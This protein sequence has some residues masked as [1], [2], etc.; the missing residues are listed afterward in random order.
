MQYCIGTKLVMAREMTLGAYNTYRGWALPEDEDGTTLGY[1]VEYT[2]G[3]KANHKDHVGYISWSPATVFEPANT[4]FN[5]LAGAPPYVIRMCAEFAELSKKVGMLGKVLHQEN[6]DKFHVAD[7]I[8]MDQQ[9]H[10][11][12]NYLRILRT[13]ILRGYE[14]AGVKV[15]VEQPNTEPAPVPDKEPEPKPAPKPKPRA[16]P[17]VAKK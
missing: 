4:P 1:L 5:F 16:R 13:R 10:A 17:K 9:H 14:A 6:T 7:I 12:Q 8:L 15:P 2:D 11:M 3:G